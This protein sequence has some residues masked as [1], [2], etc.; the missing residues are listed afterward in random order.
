MSQPVQ[1]TLAPVAGFR[2]EGPWAIVNAGVWCADPAA[3]PDGATIHPHPFLDITSWQA[4]FVDGRCAY[5]DALTALAKALDACHGNDLGQSYWEQCLGWFVRV[6]TDITVERAVLLQDISRQYPDA[7]F[8]GLD[9]TDFERPLDTK[10]FI[11]A[12]RLSHLANLQIMTQVARYLGLPLE[13]RRLDPAMKG[14]GLSN[15]YIQDGPDEAPDTFAKPPG[16]YRKPVVLYKTLLRKRTE[17]PLRALSL[18]RIRVLKALGA[19]VAPRSADEALRNNLANQ[20]C[21]TE[22]GSLTLALVAQNLPT[23]LLEE[24]PD[25]AAALE[26]LTPY[27]KVIVTGLGSYWNSDFAIWSAAARRQ[28][29]RFIGLQHGGTYGERDA[30]SYEQHERAIS[31]AY[32]T[33]G[34]SEDEKTVALPAPR[35][36]GITRRRTPVW[37]GPILWVGTSDTPYVYQLGPR[38]VGPQFQ[39]YFETQ[40]AFDKGLDAQVRALVLFRPYPTAFGWSDQPGVTGEPIRVTLDDFSLSFHRRMAE[41][42]L[43]LVDHPGST[44]MLEALSANIPVMCFGAPEDFDIRPSARP[45]YDALA[46][47]GLFHSTAE[48]AARTVNRIAGDVPRW[49]SDHGRQAAAQ[50]FANTFAKRGNFIT[51]WRRFLSATGKSAPGQQV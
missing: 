18:D 2:A 42:R 41:A 12:V 4:A 5:I 3:E 8:V 44:T 17:L 35:L 31:D 23:A 38:P 36:S 47:H 22:L 19:A 46:E 50:A 40:R 29:T 37:D 20:P 1:V 39:R 24:W 28:G 15:A 25:R 7:V 51:E 48:S 14:T 16:A 30:A 13:T 11:A 32:V 34:W 27:P 9:E 33:W 49:W 21:E 10:N 45:F 26:R 43:V 6:H